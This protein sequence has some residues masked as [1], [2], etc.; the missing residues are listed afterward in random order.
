MKSSRCVLSLFLALAAIAPVSASYAQVTEAPDGTQTQVS[1]IGN[2]FSIIGGTR[3]GSNLFHSFRQF[4]LDQGQTA[5][6]VDPGVQNI[7]GRVTG[8]NASMING[9][10]QV[11]G[12][13]ANLYLMNPA[14]MIFGASARLNVSGSFTA[15]TA[16]GI[17]LGDQ[18]FNAIGSNN[19]ANLIGNPNRFAFTMQQPGA[20]VNAGNLAVGQGQRIT[21]LGGAVINT[22]T[23]TAPGGNITIVASPGEKVVTILQDGSLLS[24]ALPLATGA[25]IQPLPF[26][27]LSLPQLLTGGSL[28]HATGVTVENGVVRLIGANL[29]IPSEAGTTIVSNTVNASGNTGGTVHILGKRVGLVNA[30]IDASG[31]NGGGT[32]LIGG[33]YRGQGNLPNAQRTFVSPDAV[34]R[35]DAQQQGNGGRVIVWADGATSFRG[36]VSARGAQTGAG[37][38]V[39]ISG[40]QALE[41]DGNVDVSSPAGQS[42]QLLLD[43]D[44]VVIGTNGAN[45]NELNDGQILAGD[46]PGA[47]FF[48]STDRVLQALNNGS[49]SIAATNDITINSPLRSASTAYQSSRGSRLALTAAQINLLADLALFGDIDVQASQAIMI[50]NRQIES[51]GNLSL[52]TQGNVGLTNTAL[53]LQVISACKGRLFHC[54]AAG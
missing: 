25:T 2:T 14:G 27:P 28:T 30:T 36:G 32:V 44:R 53:A 13:T 9:L 12:G 43:P 3:A 26:T 18:W 11:T 42:G 48:I 38:F 35:V 49:V 41:F 15:T 22:G 16:N 50:A 19:Y 31:S 37:G 17:G 33:D 34:I 21:L 8:G 10:I 39:E 47:T 7:L 51:A 1:L 40:K 46:S 5:N 45:N 4:G 54:V 24:L 29:S 23:L 52:A 20:I 6:F